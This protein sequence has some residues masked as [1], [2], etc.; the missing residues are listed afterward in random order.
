MSKI[1]NPTRLSE[2]FGIQKGVLKRLGILNAS[3][4][5]DT[6]LF[7][8]PLLLQ[9]SKHPE[10]S[11]SALKTFKNHFE[12][13]IKLLS[14]SK[15]NNDVAWRNARRLL[16][17]PEVNYICLG[18]SSSAGKGSGS[19]AFTTNGIMETAKAIIDLG[20]QDP[21]LFIALAVFE[22]GIGPDRISDMT[23]NIILDD[24]LKFNE[25]VLSVLKIKTRPCNITLKNG[26]SF[27]VSLPI[28][29]I[30]GKP[31]ILL[32]L[33]ILRDLPIATDWS[34]ISTAA[35]HNEALR[36]D[37]NKHI[38]EIWRKK[39]LKDKDEIKRWATKSKKDFETF[40]NLLKSE[41]PKPYDADNDPL[42]ELFWNEIAEHI[43]TT[44][45]RSINNKIKTANDAKKVVEEIIDQF[46]FL[47]EKRRL[48]EELY[49]KG[50]RRPEK[51][52]QRLFF[53]VAYSYC[54]ANG[55]D[56]TPEADT[57]NGPVDFK[58][59]SG[60]YLRVL[61]EIKLSSNSH[62]VKGYLNQLEIYKNA[63]ETMA[64]YY[65]VIDVDHLMNKKDEELIKLKNE[66]AK[67][68]QPV[69]QIVFID[70]NKKASASLRSIT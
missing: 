61:V 14:A 24:I 68:K 42:G 49:Y 57:G 66:C 16:M 6:K 36:T 17:F 59:S 7:I 60:F 31:I 47:I 55:L 1:R 29:P 4:D 3:L 25:R 26:N 43:A 19:G 12:K 62:V 64:A 2:A 41:P 69:S 46:Q 27:K 44:E 28:N 9:N 65:I 8:D 18:Y 35:A 34:D 30:N 70:G 22:E 39:T 54:K 45:K 40:L 52:A 48:S 51:A 20:I 23:A 10:F 13:V 58:F 32:P 21:D 37:V 38:A 5:S 33:D 63:E 15:I 56:V 67:K 53:A 11:K 50:G